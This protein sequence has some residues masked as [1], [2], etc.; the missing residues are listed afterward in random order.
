MV[1][2]LVAVVLSPPPN[3]NRVRARSVV[4]DGSVEPP[5]ARVRVKRLPGFL[6]SV[7]NRGRRRRPANG[8]VDSAAA[9]VVVDEVVVEVDVVSS[10]RE[11]NQY[12]SDIMRIL[13]SIKNRMYK[14]D[15]KI[16]SSH[17]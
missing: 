3:L 4:D 12:L 14:G 8:S 6:A 1:V 2:V 16:L 11:N 5:P 7:L 17:P 15:L 9:V 10:K 13:K